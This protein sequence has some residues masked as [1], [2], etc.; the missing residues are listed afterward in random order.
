M[1]KLL[2][3]KNEYLIVIIY[4]NLPQAAKTR[5]ESEKSRAPHRKWKRTYMYLKG[6]WSLLKNLFNFFFLTT[7]MIS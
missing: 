6:S 1:D 3:F 7:Q 2:L 4:N 5:N